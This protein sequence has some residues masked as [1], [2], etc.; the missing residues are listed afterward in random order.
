[1]LPW[2]PLVADAYRAIRFSSILDPG[3]AKECILD[4]GIDFAQNHGNAIVQSFKSLI[5]SNDW[6]EVRS[7]DFHYNR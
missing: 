5:R 1:M 4:E 3:I 2:R 6:N 7:N